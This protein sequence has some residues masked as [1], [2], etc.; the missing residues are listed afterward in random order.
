M[1]RWDRED[2]LTADNGMRHHFD[3]IPGAIGHERNRLADLYRHSTPP[4]ARRPSMHTS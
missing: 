3:H 4:G 2:L 1:D